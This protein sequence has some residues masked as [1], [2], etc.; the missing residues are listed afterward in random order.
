MSRDNK[1][2]TEAYVN[3]TQAIANMNDRLRE[4][5]MDFHDLKVQFKREL[6]VEFPQ[7]SEER[8]Q[9]MAQRLLNEKLL[10]DEKMSRFP[11]QHESFRPNLPC[12]HERLIQA[13]SVLLDSERREL[14]RSRSYKPRMTLTSEGSRSSWLNDLEEEE[15]KEELLPEE[16]FVDDY[17]D[18]RWLG[19]DEPGADS[20]DSAR[21]GS[22]AS[23]AHGSVA[24]SRYHQGSELKAH[25][26]GKRQRLLERFAT[27][28]R[29]FDDF[30]QTIREL[31]KLRC[32]RGNLWDVE[33]P[34]SLFFDFLSQHFADMPPEARKVVSMLQGMKESSE[35][36]K[37]E[38]EV[39]YASFSSWCEAELA[40]K[41]RELGEAGDAAALLLAAGEDSEAKIAAG[42]AKLAELVK[43]L[44]KW[45]VEKENATLKRSLS[46]NCF[47]IENLLTKL[48][49]HAAQK[50]A[51]FLAVYHSNLAPELDSLDFSSDR[52]EEMLN[53]LRDRFSDERS[54]LEKEDS[55][56]GEMTLHHAHQSLM[57]E[58]STLI[59][60]AEAQQAELK[61]RKATEEKA[62]GS[63]KSQ[64]AD[65]EASK[66]EMESYLSEVNQ[67]CTQKAKDYKE[68]QKLREG[69]L[70]AIEKTIDLL[71]SQEIDRTQGQTPSCCD[72]ERHGRLSLTQRAT[73]L[74]SLSW[75]RSVSAAQSRAAEYLQNQ[76]MKIN[77]RVLFS[78][79]TRLSSAS[80]TGADPMANVERLQTEMDSAEAQ[81]AQLGAEI[82]ELQVQLSEN[83][84]S[85]SN[86]T[87]A[88]KLEKAENEKIVEDA[89]SATEAVAKAIE[90]LKNFYAGV[91][92]IQS[93]T[94]KLAK[95]PEIFEAWTGDAG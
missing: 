22:R 46:C 58:L 38:E 3:P 92:F 29:A 14:R 25:L 67:S 37:H 2:N 32:W 65:A 45:E 78:M 70:S 39:Q 23:S 40:T 5:K 73:A 54:K 91:A 20:A 85:V 11:V 35:K 86:Q 77:S 6:K 75:P 13:Q 82:T 79:A 44:E 7:A 33:L 16:P 87:D 18:W 71:S 62:L 34:Q 84:E 90:V 12:P 9:A 1:V 24:S 27:T 15:T 57:Q 53:E 31:K 49:P 59:S 52:I 88:R 48:P 64:L 74:V 43:D 30:L 41:T 95:A 61:Q 51:A 63:S 19:R 93:R 80:G 72:L 42:K 60:Q 21:K 55:K 83:A 28:K 76:A 68:R 56:L 8:L 69:E 94:V 89:K 81:T 36:E 10:A 17:L 50:V 26:K 4:R 66:K 47:P